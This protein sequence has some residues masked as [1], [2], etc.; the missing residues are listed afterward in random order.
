M[1]FGDF[2]MA[3]RVNRQTTS[4]ALIRR[5]QATPGVADVT[6]FDGL[7]EIVGSLS[8]PEQLGIKAYWNS[9]R[10]QLNRK[11]RQIERR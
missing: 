2:L 11:D 7:L 5:V 8:M 4:P 6:T 3:R 9:Y 1:T 10:G